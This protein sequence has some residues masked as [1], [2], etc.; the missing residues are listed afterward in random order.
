M[1]CRVRPAHLSA[2]SC[3][4]DA[5]SLRLTAEDGKQYAFTFDHV[6]GPAASQ[7]DIFA[8]VA[9]VV[10]SALDGYK[11]CGATADAA[12]YGVMTAAHCI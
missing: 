7:T 6:F 5:A 2:V 10:Q 11:V 9:D 4:S 1:F 12:S 3:S 8:Q